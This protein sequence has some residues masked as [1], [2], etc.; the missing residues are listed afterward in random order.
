MSYYQPSATP[1]AYQPV[2]PSAPPL[3]HAQYDKPIPYQYGQYA[4]PINRIYYP[5]GSTN[6]NEKCCHR[7]H[8]HHDDISDCCILY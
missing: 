2:T 8:K 1:H 5:Q 7:H 3:S 6:T 4:M